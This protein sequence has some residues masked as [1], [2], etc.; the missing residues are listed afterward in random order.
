MFVYKVNVEIKLKINCVAYFGWGAPESRSGHVIER[1]GNK[2]K[3]GK[4]DHDLLS[5]CLVK[6]EE[7]KRELEATVS[8][9]T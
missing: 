5:R 4:H 7:F 9:D 2:R 8:D 6:M 3:H 1:A